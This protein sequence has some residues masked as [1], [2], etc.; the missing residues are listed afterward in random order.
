MRSSACSHASQMLA[1]LLRT[2]TSVNMM[3]GAF[4]TI[5]SSFLCLMTTSLGDNMRKQRLLHAPPL[6]PHAPASEFSSQALLSR[7]QEGATWP[8]L[9]A[10]CPFQSGKHIQLTSAVTDA[11]EHAPSRRSSLLQQQNPLELVSAE[12][13]FT[14]H[15]GSSGKLLGGQASGW[16]LWRWRECSNHLQ[17]STRGTQLKPRPHGI[18]M[19]RRRCQ[20][21]HKTGNI[22]LNTWNMLSLSHDMTVTKSKRLKVCSEAL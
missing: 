14:K 2:H 3:E 16:G 4:V 5:T 12:E 20:T 18:E 8:L 15:R 1:S 6:L 13:A 22:S 21:L 9:L 17:G 7:T 19:G 10:S 11:P